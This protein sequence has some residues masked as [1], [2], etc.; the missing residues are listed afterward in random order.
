[1][2]VGRVRGIRV[3]C[4]QCRRVPRS[5][6]EC[7]IRL[8]DGRITGRVNERDRL[9]STFGSVARLRV[10]HARGFRS[11]GAILDRVP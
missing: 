5:V 10:K 9:V 3:A 11:D 7:G 6:N 8:V 2:G 1:M 4:I